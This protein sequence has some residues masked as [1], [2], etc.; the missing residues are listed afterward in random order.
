[1]TYS[2]IL[3]SCGQSV[4]CLLASICDVTVYTSCDVGTPVYIC[5]QHITGQ[6]I[7]LPDLFDCSGLVEICLGTWVYVFL[8]G[9]GMNI[10]QQFRPP[11]M[12]CSWSYIDIRQKL[13]ARCAMLVVRFE[14]VYYNMFKSTSPELFTCRQSGTALSNA[15]NN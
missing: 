5:I 4:H 8:G 9:G 1:M 3:T 11:F 6:N 2:C 14:C 12:L 13:L 7:S 15:K 10:K